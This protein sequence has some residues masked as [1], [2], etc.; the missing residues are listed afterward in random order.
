MVVVSADPQNDLCG[1]NGINCPIWVFRIT[2][3]QAQL[4]LGGEGDLGLLATYHFGM[5]DIAMSRRMEHGDIE[6]SIEVD[7]FNGAIYRPAYCYEST[8]DDQ[9][10]MQRSPRHACD[11]H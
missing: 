3:K 7:R 2:G 4:L 5:R 9:G 11:A 6:E 1:A 10:R 8:L